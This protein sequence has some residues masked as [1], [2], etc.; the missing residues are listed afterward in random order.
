MRAI[1]LVTLG[2]AHEAALGQHDRR[3]L[4]G[5][6]LRL[7]DGLRGFALDDLRAAVVA[8][9]FGIR[10]DLAGDEFLQLRL[11]LE[12]A[13]EL[14]ALLGELLLLLADLHFLEF[15][16][17]AQL[18][19][20][21]GLGLDLG[22]LEALHEHRLRLVLA[23]DD[24]DHLVEIEIRRQ[25]AVEDVQALIDLVEP[26]LQAARDGLVR[27]CSHS[28]SR[29]RRPMTLGLPSSVITLRFTR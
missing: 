20:E 23:A 14:L 13:L 27:N 26:E 8:V 22:E 9:F 16:E 5:D 24:A 2:R 10:L 11:R 17:M 7:V 19:L 12:H 25:Q 1:D 15:G 21:D 6:Q 29:S 4:V 18:G 3:G 28:L